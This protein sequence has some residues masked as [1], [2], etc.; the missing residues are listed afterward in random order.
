MNSRKNLSIH[1]IYLFIYLCL[2]YCAS[3]PSAPPTAKP[4]G[5]AIR[6]PANE[7]PATESAD[8]AESLKLEP[9]LDP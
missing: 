6:P 9:I 4:G 5:P 2:A 7:A 8:S 3:P 1:S